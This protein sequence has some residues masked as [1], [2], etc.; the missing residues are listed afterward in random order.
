MSR[1][2]SMIVTL[3][4]SASRESYRVS[5]S[6]GSTYTVATRD[7]DGDPEYMAVWGCDCAAGRHGR[8]CKHV[9]AAIACA[10]ELL[11]R[12]ERGV[13]SGPTSWDVVVDGGEVRSVTARIG[14]AA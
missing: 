11:D 13:R 6:S 7:H 4:E 10:H 12:W 14:G 1:A 8:S 9:G 2:S 5:S 3:D